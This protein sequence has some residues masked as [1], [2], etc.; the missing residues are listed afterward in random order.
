MKFCRSACQIAFSGLMVLV[1]SASS[2]RGEPPGAVRGVYALWDDKPL[3]GYVLNSPD[4]AGVSLR[5]HWS[6]ME[7]KEGEFSWA[8]AANIAAARQAGK[9]VMLRVS[10]GEDTP[11]WVYEA[12]ATSFWF[13]NATRFAAT[14]GRDL[15]IP[16]PWD[17]IFVEKW[18]AFV[19]ALGKKYGKDETIVLVHMAGPTQS[20]SEMHLPKT[21]IDKKNWDK[22]GYSKDKLI[23]A[24]K[25]AIDA[26]A[27]AFPDKR[28]AL[29][30][31][32]PIHDDGVALEVLAYASRKLGRRL[33]VQHNA[34]SDHT[35]QRFKPQQWVGSYRDKAT[36]GYQLLCPVTPRGK[37]NDEGR[38]FGGPLKPAFQLGLQSGASYFEIYPIDLKNEGA[39][40]DIR[41]LARQLRQ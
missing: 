3:P 41:N 10:P 40:P 29:N 30:V 18:T 32:M 38:R 33:C 27:S 13:K 22:A 9:K 11:A 19:A 6:E 23:G 26:Y 12:G 20:S 28:L 5:G 36:L 8:F 39:A 21:E 34:L 24:W 15:Q 37:F 1:A 7:P 25:S 4:L 35:N 31:A 17:S 2:A 14:A 16:I